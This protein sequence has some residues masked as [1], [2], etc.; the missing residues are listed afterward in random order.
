MPIALSCGRTLEALPSIWP[1]LGVGMLVTSVYYVAASLVFPAGKNPDFYAHYWRRKRQFVGL[2]WLCEFTGQDLN[3]LLRW[4]DL[5]VRQQ[6]AACMR[7]LPG[8]CTAWARICVVNSATSAR[9]SRAET[10]ALTG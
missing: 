5:L 6:G 3:L 10:V 4:L 7:C 1:V 8:A 9:P 2:G